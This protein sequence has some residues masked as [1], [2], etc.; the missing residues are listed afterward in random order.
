M[1]RV[2]RKFVNVDGKFGR[3][4]CPMPGSASI[5][6]QLGD[7]DNMSIAD[8]LAQLNLTE[9]EI[10]ALEGFLAITHGGQHEEASFGEF[11]RWWA[12]NNYD[13]DLFMD[14]CLTYKFRSGQS[15]FAR[16]FFDEALAT[17][18]LDYILQAPANSVVDHG[19]RVTITTR[20]GQSFNARRLI[21]SVP[22]NV[23]KDV[24]FSP[25]LHPLKLS[26]SQ[27]GHV[28]KVSKVHVE[29][30]NPELRSFAGQI[31]H[32]YNKLTYAF[33]D[34]TTLAGNT[35]LVAFGSSQ[36]GAHLNAEDDIEITKAAFQ[37]FV[38][39]QLDIKRV[40]FHN[41]AK[42]EFAQGAWEWLR[43]GMIA[44]KEVLETLRRAQGNVHFANADWAFLW[45]GF[46]DGAIEDGARVAID[47]KR[48][49]MALP[50]S[51]L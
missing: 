13:M 21:C 12:L 5:S 35:H 6:N 39:G 17:G 20:S 49:L 42:D 47:V 3:A 10:A 15:N 11:L 34:G 18:K 43:P 30:A 48:E 40:V 41:W 46:I 8:R 50:S 27:R 33:G 26:A 2:V 32:P 9:I 25:P 7:F 45:R 23:L 28:N 24:S 38:D 51:R 44:N 29:C 19:D 37:A 1:D 16:Q 22:L 31:A 36:P 14:Q 4:V